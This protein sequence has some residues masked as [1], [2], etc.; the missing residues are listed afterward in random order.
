MSIKVYDVFRRRC[1]KLDFKETK[2]I[3]FD[4]ADQ[5]S[6]RNEVLEKAKCSKKFSV[7][8]YRIKCSNNS[9]DT[10]VKDSSLKNKDLCDIAILDLEIIAKFQ[11]K[12]NS[13][14]LCKLFLEICQNFRSVCPDELYFTMIELCYQNKNVCDQINNYC[15]TI[16]GNVK[17]IENLR[18]DLASA[19]CEDDYKDL[20]KECTKYLCNVS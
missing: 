3:K 10:N 2:E 20:C 5:E 7:L 1:Y 8:Y 4:G 15:Y 6:R 16:M 14:D 17:T 12:C 13:K 19:N 11:N 18:D 9:F